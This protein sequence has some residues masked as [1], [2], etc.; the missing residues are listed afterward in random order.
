MCN[1]SPPPQG[2][3]GAPNVLKLYASGG[4][5]ILKSIEGKS[6][7]LTKLV[8]YS[9]YIYICVCAVTNAFPCNECILFKSFVFN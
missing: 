8:D 7:K 5:N 2:I 3:N 4:I 6:I 1:P 9:I